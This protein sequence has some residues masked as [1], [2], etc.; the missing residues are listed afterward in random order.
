VSEFY[1][2]CGQRGALAN[3]QWDQLFSA[4]QQKH[5]KEAAELTRRIAGTLPDG[6]IDALPENPTSVSDQSS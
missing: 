6:W 4:Y 2:S 5:P 3:A 1:Q